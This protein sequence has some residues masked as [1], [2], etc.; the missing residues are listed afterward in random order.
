MKQLILFTLIT[1]TIIINGCGSEHSQIRFKDI[2]EIEKLNKEQFAKETA[3]I[4]AQVFKEIGNLLDKYTII[5]AEF[6]M[7]IDELH[8]NSVGQMYKYGKV[9]ASKDPVIRNEYLKS[10][11][12]AMSS[13]MEKMEPEVL[14]VFEKKLNKRLPELDAC[15]SDYIKRKFN[16]LFAIMDFLDFDKI[17]EKYPERD[18]SSL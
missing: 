16:D 3:T 1:T 9:L 10:S 4:Y 6:E 11:I 12:I 17:Q 15:C 2:S 8:K 14:V 18:L 13:A 5:D 7:E